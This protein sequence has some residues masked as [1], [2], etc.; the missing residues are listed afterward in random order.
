MCNCVKKLYLVVSW[1]MEDESG[2]EMQHSLK[3]FTS[4]IFML[5]TSVCTGGN[6][7]FSVSLENQQLPCEKFINKAFKV[8]SALYMSIHHAPLHK[9]FWYH[10][11]IRKDKMNATNQ[12]K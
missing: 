7:A 5:V 11:Q 9:L 12:S 4:E 2:C 8:Q 3:Q 10:Y 6:A 1:E